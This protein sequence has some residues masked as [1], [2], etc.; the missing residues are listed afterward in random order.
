VSRLSGGPA[1][2]PQGH[3]ES[4]SPSC[5]RDRTTPLLRSYSRFLVC[6]R[7]GRAL[8]RG[9]CQTF[10][11][12][13]RRSCRRSSDGVRELLRR[14]VSDAPPGARRITRSTPRCSPPPPSA[15]KPPRRGRLL[16]GV[17]RR[18]VGRPVQVRVPAA[19][20]F[21]LRGPDARVA[22]QCSRALGWVNIHQRHAGL[23]PDR[24]HGRRLPSR[25]RAPVR[26]VASL[27]RSGLTV[28]KVA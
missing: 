26:L 13:E 5:T 12:S 28:R 23:L 22:Q 9:L 2:W 14:G 6:K 15:S 1:H 19:W 18:A 3:R 7:G 10:A 16:R 17:R 20:F 21:P 25:Q 4:E 24:C 27:D 8:T 11:K